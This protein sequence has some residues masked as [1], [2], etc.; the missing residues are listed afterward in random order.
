MI[1]WRISEYA[2]LDGAGGMAVGGRWHSKGRPIVYSAESSA[3]AMLE[4]FVHLETDTLPPPFQLLKLEAE[5][6]LAFAEW[7][8][9]ENPSELAA[10]RDWGDA[11]LSRGSTMLACVP[12]VIAPGGRNWLI[13][14][15]HADASKVRIVGAS[16][17]P[18]DRRLFG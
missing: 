17:W 4:M 10:T 2:S 8:A 16:R 14:P 12:S 6:G 13:N 5:N 18:W 1:L 15:L 3:L 7:T 9:R 11:W